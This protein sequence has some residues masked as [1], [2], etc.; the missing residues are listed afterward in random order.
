L[1]DYRHTIEYYE[2]K[3]LI[4]VG[5]ASLP[6]VV[7]DMLQEALKQTHFH[8]Y[9]FRG[10]EIGGL[11]YIS[12]ISTCIASDTRLKALQLLDVTFEHSNNVDIFCQA[13]NNHNSLEELTLE[14][15]S[16]ESPEQNF[17]DIIN[18]LKSKTI[19]KMYIGDRSVPGTLFSGLR[20]A[21]FLQSNPSLKKLML[22]DNPLSGEDFVHMQ[23]ALQ[24]NTTLLQLTYELDTLPITWRRLISVV[25]DRTSLNAAYESNH[26]CCVKG[27]SH[28][29]GKICYKYFNTGS[30]PEWNR[31]KKIY[32]ILSM[33]NMNRQNAAHFESENM[34]IKYLPQI[35]S[36][37]KQFSE[38]NLHN[39][40][41]D[42]GD[43]DVKPLSIVYEIMRDWKMPEL[44]NLALLN[45]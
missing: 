31:R 19:E 14:H 3:Y 43:H 12:F 35:L 27:F 2:D 8:S 10:N 9:D 30:H 28:N 26:H 24:N 37:L 7:L 18:K 21:E 17:G 20:P 1:V 16:F 38:H 15:I 39:E 32:T 29:N 6:R 45:E 13:V 25:F 42:V 33:R 11:G 5:D 40:D 36:I 4:H 34:G 44:Y 22:F 23:T 41:D